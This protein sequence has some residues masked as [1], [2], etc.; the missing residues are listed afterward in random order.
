[1][2]ANKQTTSP[3][4]PKL[5]T[6]RFIL[7]T[8][9]KKIEKALTG[10]QVLPYFLRHIVQLRSLNHLE[11]AETRQFLP[12]KTWNNVHMQVENVLPCRFAV[13][14]YY[15]YAIRS[16]GF[17]YRWSNML[18][19]CVDSASNST[20]MSKM[21]TKCAFGITW[22]CPKFNGRMSKKDITASSS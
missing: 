10:S 22:V 17:L 16:C 8:S 5:L 6:V 12:I 14:L 3:L 18:G 15:A 11:L 2:V 7:V 1:M 21:S 9:T 19:Y 13:L 20:G 4:T